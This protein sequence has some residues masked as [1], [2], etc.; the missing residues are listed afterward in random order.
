MDLRSVT[1]FQLQEGKKLDQRDPFLFH[2]QWVGILW[3]LP[4]PG[5][6]RSILW[7]PGGKSVAFS[8]KKAKGAL[9]LFLFLEVA[10][11]DQSSQTQMDIQVRPGQ[12]GA[13]TDSCCISSC[14]HLRKK[15]QHF[16]SEYLLLETC[17]QLLL[18]LLS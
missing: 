13:G 6:N 14:R 16:S 5:Q 12:K 2:L 9:A 15:T 11:S 10:G 7:V 3:S 18:C 8:R 17:Q 4:P 1:L